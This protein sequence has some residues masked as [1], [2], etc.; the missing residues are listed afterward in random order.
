MIKHALVI[1]GT[2]MLLT[3]TEFVLSKSQFT[4]IIA[5]HKHKVEKIRYFDEKGTFLFGDY[6]QIDDLIKTME[7]NV[8]E[9]G[10][11][12]FLLI[13]MHK[14]E[15]SFFSN[16]V[17]LLKKDCKIYHVLSSQ[18][19]LLKMKNDLCF[20][21]HITYYQIHLG[22]KLND[23]GNKRWLNHFEINNGVLK[24]FKLNE[25]VQIGLL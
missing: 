3:S 18:T 8:F 19:N 22:Y 14:N 23:S 17:H 6:N 20:L 12:D 13:W 25:D 21:S 4:T 9:H 10:K 24:A 11:Y 16:A 2:G 1:G 5:R 7:N 15:C